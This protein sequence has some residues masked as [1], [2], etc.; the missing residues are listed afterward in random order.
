M[1]ETDSYC[2]PTDD[3]GRPKRSAAM[4]PGSRYVVGVFMLCSLV[5]T[6][7]IGVIAY[8]VETLQ[9]QVDDIFFHQRAVSTPSLNN[10]LERLTMLSSAMPD[11]APS[12]LML[13]KLYLIKARASTDQTST[14]FLGAARQQLEQVRKSQPAH[15]PAIGMLVWLEWQEGLPLTQRLAAL[16]KALQTGSL[17]Q[18]N[19]WLLGPVVVA[20][21]QHLPDDIRALSGPM[22]KSML[23]EQ[24]SRNILINAMYENKR[25]LPFT[26][27]S[28][29]RDTSYLLRTLHAIYVSSDIR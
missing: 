21:W 24:Q 19:Q 7:F 4:F 16:R 9:K 10:M 23:S 27:F 26:E 3:T 12:R 5:L 22:I 1:T 11:Y 8:N 25:F 13:A 28:P 2:Q 18:T 14:E 17:E 6:S 15:Y 20:D 29:N